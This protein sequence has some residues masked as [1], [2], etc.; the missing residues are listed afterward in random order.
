M[1]GE[2]QKMHCDPKLVNSDAAYAAFIDQLL[3]ANLV[4]LGASGLEEVGIFFIWKKRS[5]GP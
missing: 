3:W 2:D 1:D 4:V 5:G